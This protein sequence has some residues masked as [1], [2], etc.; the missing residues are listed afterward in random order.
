[1]VPMPPESVTGCWP[2]A[3]SMA[4]IRSISGPWASIPPLG[5]LHD[6]GGDAL[7]GQEH[8][9]H[10]H[11]LLVT[12]D[13][14]LGKHDVR[15]VVIGGN[16]PVLLSRRPGGLGRL[17]GSRRSAGGRGGGVGVA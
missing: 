16:L 2:Q 4:F 5:K 1:M 17:S 6:L 10:F 3:S 15:V 14:H 7:L 13:H 12:G 8:L 11:G 9:T